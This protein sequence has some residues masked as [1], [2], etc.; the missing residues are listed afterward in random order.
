MNLKKLITRYVLVALG[1][2]LS[3]PMVCS[4]QSKNQLIKPCNQ[5]EKQGGKVLDCSEGQQWIIFKN[6]RK[7]KRQKAVHFI[8][9]DCMMS[10]VV[11]QRCSQMIIVSL[12]LNHQSQSLV[13]YV[14]QKSMH[15]MMKM[16][17]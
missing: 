7:R 10:K 15:G 2:I 4:A 11:K 17:Y 13:M 16:E 6:N 1:L 5:I 8:H 12:L 3:V 14:S 9:L